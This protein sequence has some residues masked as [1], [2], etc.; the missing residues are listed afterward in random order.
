MVFGPWTPRYFYWTNFNVEDLRKG[1]KLHIPR[2]Q[3]TGPKILQNWDDKKTNNQKWSLK[4]TSPLIIG[5]FYLLIEE[6]F[7]YWENL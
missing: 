6:V 7:T 2:I 3:P 4:Q 1:M 5:S